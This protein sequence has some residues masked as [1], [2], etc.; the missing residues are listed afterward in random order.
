MTSI[1]CVLQSLSFLL[2]G[3][4]INF[5]QAL[6][7][8]SKPG[9]VNAVQPQSWGAGSSFEK[10]VRYQREQLIC[11]LITSKFRGNT[12]FSQ[13]ATES[14]TARHFD[15]SARGQVYLV[16]PVGRCLE[17]GFSIVLG[18]QLVLVQ[19][20]VLLQIHW[21]CGLILLSY[22]GSRGV[23]SV[24]A[25]SWC[26]AVGEQLPTEPWEAERNGGG[27]CDWKTQKVDKKPQPRSLPVFELFLSVP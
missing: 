24:P 19:A 7:G 4:S 17:S 15:G 11:W 6:Q 2:R 22:S 5:L 14:P 20:E 1:W 9:I 26:T 8:L 27:R 21:A 10:E 18:T 23:N 16:G 3:A 13:R 25:R 12:H